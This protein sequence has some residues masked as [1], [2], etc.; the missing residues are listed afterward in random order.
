MNTILKTLRNFALTAIVAS[1]LFVVP[2]SS[3]QA[4]AV[5]D[6]GLFTTVLPGNDDGST[7]LV[8]VGFNLNFFGNSWN[9]LYV[10]N[11]GNVTF[12]GPLYTYTPW[13][14]TGG[15]MAMLAPFFADV[16]T[17]AGNIVTYGTNTLGGRNVF[18]VN[19][20]DVGYYS[21][22]TDKLNS[23]Q[24]IITDRVDIAAGDFDFEFNYDKIQWETGDAS[25]GSGGLGGDSASAGWTNG[26]GAYYQFPGSLANGAL[27]DGGSN[28]LIAGSLNSSIAGQ[29]IFQVRNG[30]VVGV[31]EPASL[32][33]LSFGLI[34]LVGARRKFKK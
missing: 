24:L 20:I 27:L 1:L 23:F 21:Y 30:Q 31:P 22:H 5:H 25:S 17:R 28:A 3:V 18:G 9:D 32:L 14:I 33:L 29:Y 26:A 13:A 11:N 7:A 8:G 16:D 34:G 6:A 12:T 2:V 4:G 10:N 15:A 19:W